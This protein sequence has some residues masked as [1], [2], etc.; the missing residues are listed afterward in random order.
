[1]ISFRVH[2]KLSYRIV[3]YHCTICAG[4]VREDMLQVSYFIGLSNVYLPSC[5]QL[6]VL[7]TLILSACL[8]VCLSVWNTLWPVF[9]VSLCLSVFSAIDNENYNS[10]S[11]YRSDTFVAFVI[12]VIVFYHVL[13]FVLVSPPGTVVPDGLMLM[14]IMFVIICLIWTILP[15]AHLNKQI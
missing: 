6:Y 12:D 7:I 8:S 15:D 1:M 4:I 3:S 13:H 14:Y 9:D 10:N 11:N 2:V 5:A